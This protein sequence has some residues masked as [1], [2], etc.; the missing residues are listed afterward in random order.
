MLSQGV[1]IVAWNCLCCLCNRCTTVGSRR[2]IIESRHAVV[3]R[4]LRVSHQ[5]VIVWPCHAIVEVL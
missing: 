2:A 4:H 5:V 3:K 1:G